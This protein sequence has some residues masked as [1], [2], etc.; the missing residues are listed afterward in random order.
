MSGREM[1]R[2]VSL[3]LESLLIILMLIPASCGKGSIVVKDYLTVIR[4]NPTE[5]DVQFNLGIAYSILERDREAAEAFKEAIRL[6][7]DDANAHFNLGVAYSIL[8]QGQEAAESYKRA[9]SIK[10]IKTKHFKLGWAYYILG[11]FQESAEELQLA[12]TENEPHPITSHFRLGLAYNGLGR[13]KKA[14]ETFRRAV[15]LNPKVAAEIYNVYFFIGMNYQLLCRNQEA[16]EAYKQSIRL[17]PDFPYSYLN[18]GGLYCSMENKKSALELYYTLKNI[19]ENLA[20]KLY[21]LIQK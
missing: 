12:I 10:K 16:V 5:A 14:I 15:D 18:L 21:E 19:D 8:G 1:H 3:Y 11:R 7:P 13:H 2:T 9:L 6:N 17:R 20:K 4:E